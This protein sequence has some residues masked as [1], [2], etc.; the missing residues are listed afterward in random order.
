MKALIVVILLLIPI[1]QSAFAQHETIQ[2]FIYINDDLAKEIQGTKKSLPEGS[3]GFFGDLYKAGKGAVGGIASGYITSF[4]DVGINAIGALITHNSRMKQQWEETVAAENKYS[5]NINTVSEINDFYKETSNS[6]CMDPNGMHFDGIGC[7][8]KENNDTAFYIS[9]HIDRSKL[10]RIIRHSKFELVLDTVIISP[11]HSNLPN[12]TLDIPYSFNE[13]KNFTLSMKI[14]LTSSWI[15]NIGQIQRDQEL[16]K[17]CINI[18]VEENLLDEK[19]YLRYVRNK[20]NPSKYQVVGESFIVPRSFMGYRNRDNEYHDIWGTGEYKLTI[21]LQET[22]DVTDEYR[23]NWK[24]D[25]K[26]RKQMKPKERFFKKTWKTVTDQK[27]DKLSE[28]WVITTL[29]APADVITTE[30]IEKL[31]LVQ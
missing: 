20:G 30:V 29:K 11:V 22:C 12:T 4:F 8:R 19:G 23:N 10:D 28:S 16:G 17:F 27:W 14:S 26:R 9:C 21:E 2:T 5:T 24:V 25:R 3:R 31:G 6:G 15:N 1:S 13:R 18:P 7:L